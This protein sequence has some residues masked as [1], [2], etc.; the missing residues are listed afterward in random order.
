MERPNCRDPVAVEQRQRN[1]F[2]RGA[3]RVHPRNSTRRRV[4]L[5][6][7]AT[8]LG[9]WD[10]C[11][12]DLLNAPVRINDLGRAIG[13]NH[14]HAV[15]IQQRPPLARFENVEEPNVFAAPSLLPRAIGRPTQRARFHA[16]PDHGRTWQR[17]PGREAFGNPPGLVWGRPRKSGQKPWA[18]M[19]TGVADWF[20][21]RLSPRPTPG[22]GLLLRAV[23]V[24]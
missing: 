20:P 5:N 12:G 11:W 24:A 1:D 6:W 3:M 10:R 8:G 22:R 17:R 18:Q 21:S 2:G 9:E 14:H 23:G 7:P 4:K 19:N 13:M 15:V 16:T